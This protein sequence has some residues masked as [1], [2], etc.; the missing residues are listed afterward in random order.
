MDRTIDHINAV[1]GFAEGDTGGHPRD[2]RAYFAEFRE[3]YA[4]VYGDDEMP[5][6]DQ[7]TQWAEQVIASGVHCRFAIRGET[8]RD[9]A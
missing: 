8:S 4:G 7:L 3:Q 1:T 5:T 2:V 6:Q 9:N